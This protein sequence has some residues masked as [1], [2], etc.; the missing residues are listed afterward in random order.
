MS[1]QRPTQRRMGVV[2]AFLLAAYAIFVIRAFQLQVVLADEHLA[3][4]AWG[5]ESI[6]RHEAPRGDIRDRDGDLIAGS[7]PAYTISYDPRLLLTEDR[8]E[9]TFV[10]TQLSGLERFDRDELEAWASADLTEVPRYRVLERGVAPGR[11]EALLESLRQRGVRGVF[12]EDGYARVYPFGALAGRT[13]GFLDAFGDNG[14]AGLE[15]AFDELL[16]GS[17]V[18][19]RV[20]RDASRN[21]YL[22]GDSPDIRMAAGNDVTLTID[23]ELQAIAEVEL[24]R[25]IT[26][27]HA[28]AGTAVAIQPQTGEILA[29]ASWP[30]YD[31]NTEAGTNDAGWRNPAIAAAYEPGSTVKI[32]TFAAALEEGVVGYESEIDCQNGEVLVDRYRIRDR[33][34]HDSIRAW[35]VIRDSSNIGALTMGMR[36]SQATHREYLAQFG[37][38]GRTGVEL[39]GEAQGMLPNLDR[40]W[41]ASRHATISYGY[42]FSVTPLQL[43]AATAVIANDGVRV[44]PHIVRSITS[45]G[46]VELHNGT[47]TAGTRVISARTANQVTA[48][49]VTVVSEDGTAALAAIPGYSVAGKTG[50]ARMIRATGGYADNE[51]LSVFTGFAPADAPRVAIAVMVERPDPSIGYYGGTVAAPIFAAIARRALELDGLPVSEALNAVPVEHA[52]AAEP[53]QGLEVHEPRALVGPR[54]VPDFDGLLVHEAMAMARRRG[55]TVS[56]EGTGRVVAQT[57]GSFSPATPGMAVT[58][59]LESAHR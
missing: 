59:T 18:E 32:F 45:P 16:Q 6:S 25:V 11:T 35:E 42:G 52:S 8:E 4:A 30:P 51:Y 44:Q 26:E 33:H 39:P 41:P 3:R 14:V 10:M 2:L 7:A 21:P 57:P 47:H 37:L 13:I 28:E 9:L 22:I 49:M 46:G 58:L 34:C 43:A 55:L 5:V 12:R 29:L 24:E 50:T 40:P 15:L 17:T 23:H 31:P 36:M 53:V 27:F 19:Y 54:E 38:G 20:A 1:V 56:V 48:A